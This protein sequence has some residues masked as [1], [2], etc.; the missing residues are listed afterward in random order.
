MRENTCCQLMLPKGNLRSDYLSE[1][2]P[3]ASFESRSDGPVLPAYA[4]ESGSGYGE[5]H[6]CDI[7]FTALAAPTSTKQFGERL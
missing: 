3:P 2:L 5:N 7:S 4:S 1:H 6:T